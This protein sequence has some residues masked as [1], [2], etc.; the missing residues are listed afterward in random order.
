MRAR[1]VVDRSCATLALVGLVACGSPP[2]DRPA[3]T[4]GA[5]PASSS[6]SEEDEGAGD[7]GEEVGEEAGE[8]AGEEDAASAPPAV[9][10]EVRAALDA[11]FSAST[12]R[13]TSKGSPIDGDLE[14]GLALPLVGPGFRFN[15]AKDPG[16][17]YGTV[18][19][20]QALV[21][22]AGAVHARLPGNPLTFGDL[23][24][25]RGDVIKGH[26]SHQAGR[27]VDVLFY[28]LDG[29]GA[30]FPAKAIPIDPAG[31]G[32]DYRDLA[33]PDD[34]IPVRLDVPRTWAFVEA[35]LTGEGGEDVQR[36]FVVEHVRALLLAHARAEG[37]DEAAISRFAD[38]TCQPGFPHDD[39]M[40]VR[41]FCA[42]GDIAAGCKDMKPIYPWQ[43]ERLAAAGLKVKLAGP[44]QRTRPKLKTP[45]EARAAAG[46]MDERVTEFLDRREA[47]IKK[48]HPGRTY[49]K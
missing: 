28:L 43:R 21:R 47:W 49:C 22:A 3:A 27:D 16:S 25:E 33:T 40:H 34:D 36:I 9:D 42:P 48:P 32:T 46:P 10:P 7:V 23:S 19:M 41:W 39:H 29:E 31:E 30:A 45:A 6:A 11:V 24:R 15:P 13:S 17:R 8:E 26:A 1:L 20:V 5:A 35:L 2:P 4:P 37:G 12:E 38:I 44:R 18:E 14:G